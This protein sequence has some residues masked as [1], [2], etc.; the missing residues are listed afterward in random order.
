MIEKSKPLLK[1]PFKESN[2]YVL[3]ASRKQ[4]SVYQRT[5]V[6]SN[7]DDCETTQFFSYFQRSV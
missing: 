6:I 7:F 1:Y 3:N 2:Y 5:I 4:R